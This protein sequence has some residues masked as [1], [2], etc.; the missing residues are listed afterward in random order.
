M[1]Y[2]RPP[3][4][5]SSYNGKYVLTIISPFS[6]HQPPTTIIVLSAFMSSIFKGSTYDWYYIVSVFLCLACSTEHNVLQ[7][8][9]RCFK[10]QDFLL[11]HGW[12]WRRDNNEDNK[13]H[14]KH[15][16]LLGG[17]GNLLQK[18]YLRFSF[19]SCCWP[20]LLTEVRMLSSAFASWIRP[21]RLAARNMGSGRW[22]HGLSAESRTKFP[23]YISVEG[24]RI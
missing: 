13:F 11:R 6:H 7:I 20:P 4:I 21:N 1:V 23:P 2:V 16:F 18:P 22:R 15:F 5:C 8:H 14:H 19:L 9:P 24:W 10:W 3:R 12:R 17:I